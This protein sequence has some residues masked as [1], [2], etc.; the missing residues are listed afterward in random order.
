MT[1]RTIIKCKL[2]LININ[3]V[4]NTNF[5]FEKTQFWEKARG[6]KKEGVGALGSDQDLHF[7]GKK[8]VYRIQPLGPM[9]NLT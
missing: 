4:N 2:N 6:R 7:R 9:Y 5:I 1:P 8:R 3:T